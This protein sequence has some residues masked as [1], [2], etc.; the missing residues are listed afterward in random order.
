MAW[1]LGVA[2]AALAQDMQF[3]LQETGGGAPAAPPAEGPPSEALQNALRLYQ[4]EQYPE[5]AVQFQRVVEGETQ[6]APANVQK[7]QFFL[8]KSLYHQ[9]YYQSALAVFDEISEQGRNNLFFDQ[10]LQWLAQLGSQLP[11]PAGIIDKIGRFGVDQLAQ[12]DNADNAD[13]YNQ[14][15]YLMGRSKYNQGE[16]EQ[17]IDL[18]RKV[19]R[20]NKWYVK[21]RFFEGISYIRMR[22]A[23]PAATA[24]REIIEAI[25][26]NDVTGVEDTDRMKDLAWISLAR[27]YYTAANKVNAEGERKVD[28]VLLGNAV[29]AWNK[30]DSGSEYWLDSLF[31]ESWAFFLADEYSRALG[32]VHTL[33]SPYFKESFYPEALVLK[34]VVFFTNCQMKNATAMVQLFHEKY[35][36]VKTKLD[37]LLAKYQ[38]NAAFFDFLKQVRAGEANLPPETR[39]IIASALSD[40]A[41]LAN[42]EYVALLEQEEQ[43]LNKSPSQFKGS[44]LGARI[45]QD[46]LVAKSFAIDQAGEIAKARYNRLVDEMQDLSNQIDTV[47]IEVLNY[48]RGQLDRELQAQLTAASESTGGNVFVSPEHNVWPFRGEYWRDELGYYRQQVTYKCGR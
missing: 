10:T 11:E 35:E 23:Q 45:L 47:E 36:P 46:I 37:E 41:V 16:F 28:G 30:I 2:P 32:N 21:A 27:V 24:F 26:S 43:T 12:F 15:L 42:L 20:T 18:F 5:A 44:S 7:A 33:F 34:A 29:E 6:D 9:H 31:E 25:D 4:Q 39:A 17:A 38:D 3:G 1:A 8:G 19:D 22:K 13:L 14:L 40:R 48:E